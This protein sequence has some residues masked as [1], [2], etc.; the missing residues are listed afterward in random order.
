MN[1]SAQSYTI[2]PIG[3]PVLQK[4]YHENKKNYRIFYPR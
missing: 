2:Q 4:N 1:N 3:K